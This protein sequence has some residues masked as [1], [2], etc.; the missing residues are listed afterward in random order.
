MART[1]HLIPKKYENN[2]AVI[3]AWKELY[4][5][6]RVLR[7]L[8]DNFIPVFPDGFVESQ[9]KHFELALSQYCNSFSVCCSITDFITVSFE[10][11]E[12]VNFKTQIF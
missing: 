10:S 5:S 9:E 11:Y 1:I 8:I 6:R 12:F 4:F 7:Q 3:S 2:S